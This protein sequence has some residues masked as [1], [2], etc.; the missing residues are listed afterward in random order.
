MSTPFG[1]GFQLDY[2]ESR[3]RLLRCCK[4]FAVIAKFG[5]GDPSFRGMEWPP[6]VLAGGRG[7]VYRQIIASFVVSGKNKCGGWKLT[8]SIIL[9]QLAFG[10]LFDN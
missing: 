10:S 6:G 9:Y 2:D 7:L 8:F 4:N 1:W 3:A 5:R